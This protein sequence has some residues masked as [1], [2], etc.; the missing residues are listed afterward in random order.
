M[1][2][3]LSERGFRQLNVGEHGCQTLSLPCMG[4]SHS[5]PGHPAS[6]SYSAASIAEESRTTCWAESCL[7]PHRKR[8]LLHADLR[9]LKCHFLSVRYDGVCCSVSGMVGWWRWRYRGMEA[10]PQCY[11]H[12]SSLLGNEVWQSWSVWQEKDMATEQEKTDGKPIHQLQQ[13]NKK[14]HTHTQTLVIVVCCVKET[15]NAVFS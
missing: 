3:P 1:Y 14:H 13:S 5:R 8:N 10:T 9:P 11:P 6:F 12:T 2:Y 4:Q 15:Q 7:L